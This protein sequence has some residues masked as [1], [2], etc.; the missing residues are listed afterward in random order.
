[1]ARVRTRDTAPERALR[2]ALWAAGIRG[3]R[4]HRPLPG[5]PDLSWPGRRIAVFVDGAFWH[6][7]PD[8][9][10]GQSGPFWDAK[11]D[12]NRARDRRVD[13]ELAQL[14]YEVVRVWGLRG[15]ALVRRVRGAGRGGAGARPTPVMQ[16]GPSCTSRAKP[17]PRAIRRSSRMPSAS[18]VGLGV[19]EIGR[20]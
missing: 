20:A 14:G 10:R 6:G 5:R 18:S 8:Y 11:I 16:V 1:M 4:L 19:W 17:R 7:H 13:T 3:W 2:K 12:R 9:Y 15:R